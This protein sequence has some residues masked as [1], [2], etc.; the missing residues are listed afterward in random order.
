VQVYV[1]GRVYQARRSDLGYE[2]DVDI[3]YAAL[4]SPIVEAT[5]LW[6]PPPYRDAGGARLLSIELV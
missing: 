5:V 2:A 6:A 3:P 4:T 1:N